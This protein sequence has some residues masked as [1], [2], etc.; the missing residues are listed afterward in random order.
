MDAL[1][2]E[3]SNIP[4]PRDIEINMA[5]VDYNQTKAKEKEQS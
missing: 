3:G 1:T 5:F 4:R 2:A